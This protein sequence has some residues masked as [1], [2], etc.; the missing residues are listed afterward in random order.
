MIIIVGRAFKVKYCGNSCQLILRIFLEKNVE[1]N[2]FKFRDPRVGSLEGNM[3]VKLFL[4]H[5]D[6]RVQF[7]AYI[8][9]SYFALIQVLAGLRT[10]VVR[11][12]LLT[13]KLWVVFLFC[14]FIPASYN[15]CRH[16]E[17]EP[18]LGGWDA[19]LCFC[20]SLSHAHTHFFNVYV[21]NIS[22]GSRC[23]LRFPHTRDGKIEYDE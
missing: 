5:R 2:L 17:S 7:L 22:L 19:F 23:V 15:I 12:L 20:F 13:Q 11:F 16:L 3:Q 1:D 21:R 14:G 8:P 10:D 18:G 4:L 6:A 9:D